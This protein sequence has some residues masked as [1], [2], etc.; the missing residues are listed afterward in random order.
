MSEE[1][2]KL[3]LMLLD[4]IEKLQVELSVVKAEKISSDQR[5]ANVD[6]SKAMALS[7]LAKESSNVE[8]TND[9]RDMIR[10][11]VDLIIK[12]GKLQGM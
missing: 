4:K 5:V 12:Y 9:T 6:S 2:D 8:L 7:A 1:R 11:T 10:R 3:I